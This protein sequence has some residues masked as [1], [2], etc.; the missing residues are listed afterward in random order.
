MK[1]LILTVASFVV[2]AYMYGQQV[3][4]D[5]LDGAIWIKVKN[6]VPQYGEA[7]LNGETQ[8]SGYDLSKFSFADV[9]SR[10]GVKVFYQPFK[11]IK[12]QRLNGVLRLEINDIYKVDELIKTLNK[13]EQVEYAERIPL[14][15]STLTPNDPNYN[16]STQWS[17]FQINA[18][19]AWD[20]STGSSNIKVAIVDDAV[21]ITHDDLSGVT[22]TNPGE[23]A[24]NGID[25]DNNGYIDDVNGYDVANDDNDP[26]PDSPISSFD[27]GTHVAG[28]AG[29][30]SNNNTGVA[31]IG[32]NVSIIPVKSTYSASAVTHGYEGIIYAVS[33]GADV[34]NMS[35][36]GSGSSTTAQN[37][38]TYANDE[39]SLLIAAAGNDNVS[40]IFYPAGYSEVMA[41]ASTTF[42]DSKSS[43]SNYGT[44]IDISAPGSAIYS[45]IPGNSYGTK[46]GTSMASPLVAGMAGLMLSLNPS[47]SPDDIKACILS[48]ADDIDGANPGFIGEL[49]AGRIN[50]QEAMN[51]ISTTLNWA[52][53][54]NFTAN[55]VTILEGQT[56]DF[57]DLSIYNPTTWD[58]TFNGGTPNSFSG[59][60][61]PSITYN[62]A[63]TYP[64]SLTVTNA[65]G[66]DTETKTAYIT[67][68]DLTGCDTITNTVPADQNFIWTWGAPN[69]YILGHNYLEQQYVAEKF[70]SVG[71]TSVMGADFNFV[72]GKTTDP[73]RTISIKVWESAGAQ[74]G[75]EV[76]SQDVLFQDIAD[77]ITQSGFFQTRVTFDLPVTVS[78]ND[79]YIGYETINLPGDTVACAATDDLTP[80]GTRPN[81][82]WYY[83]N[84]STNPQ[85]L[86]TG[87]QEVSNIGALELSMHV[88]PWITDL[89]PTA[90]I[91]PSPTTV[92]E[93]EF[94]TFDASSSPNIS[95]WE[96]A[97]NGTNTPYPTAVDPQ[98]T[99]NSSGTHTAYLLV[100]NSCGFYHIDSVD[101]TVNPSPNVTVVGTTDTICPGGSMD[102]TASGAASYVWT[103]AGSLSC[104]NC[105]TPTATP[106]TT[107]TYTVTGTSGAC[108]SEAYYSVVVDD[109]TPMA[110]FILSSDTI[111]EGETLSVNGAVSNGGS[112]FDWTFL[113]GTPATGVG[114]ISNTVYST[115]GIY[116]I[117]LDIENTC[118]LT[119]ATSKDVVVV[120]ASVC[121][122]GLN[123]ESAEN[124]KVFYGDLDQNVNVFKA[125]QG[126]AKA[127]IT[128]VSGQIVVDVSTIDSGNNV[129]GVQHLNRGV[130]FVVIEEQGVTNLYKFVK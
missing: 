31:S 106:A 70:T 7:N 3:N 119:D 117:D 54:A 40:S 103:P 14:L 69:G 75:T 26:N 101:V 99:M 18:A 52:P 46:Q 6:N 58:W 8:T 114:S 1:K 124:W 94:I 87:W 12:D 95:S 112:T 2:G 123:P 44:W 113:G 130:Y 71:P 98:V 34:I 126:K 121:A 23:I 104:G 111:C 81:S 13:N 41:V 115:A 108:S 97:I 96:W 9:I 28:I 92:C 62:T 59:Q 118:G 122:S 110:D 42:G 19:Q 56:I 60:S 66:T 90:I 4:P 116:T 67:V 10:Y 33:V 77:N 120:P 47:L 129:I 50:A 73:N 76:Y 15:K 29:A 51:C 36:G 86:P 109:Q 16:S 128:N 102:F 43:F 5:Y 21:E 11:N 38:I 93:G 32:H 68:N 100:E 55:L 45:T 25:D 65:N 30:S 49:G 20:F 35:W 63:G 57:T 78:T 64:V 85:G 88:Y 61:P 53:E 83:V 27:H 37:I 17:L 84:P 24:N 22:W 127:Y 72:V 39:G 82:V 107:T 48:S 89:P 105:A 79:F 91:N 74:P 125:T 80:D